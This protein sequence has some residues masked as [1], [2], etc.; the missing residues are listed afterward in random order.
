M[1]K[2]SID[3]KEIPNIP[4]LKINTPTGG[5]D[6]PMFKPKFRQTRRKSQGSVVT[7][8]IPTTPLTPISPNEIIE[9]T[10][11]EDLNLLDF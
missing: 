2:L 9:F 10:G 11:E 3:E 4:F 8:L 5:D 6:S 7:P 1:N